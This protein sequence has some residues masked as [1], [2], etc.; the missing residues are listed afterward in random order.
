MKADM[1]ETSPIVLFTYK[2]PWHTRRTVEALQANELALQSDLFVF[3]DAARDEVSVAAVKE[4]REYLRTV[5]GFRSVSLIQREVNRGL[6]ANIID[7]VSRV[8]SRYKRVIVLEDD[9]VTSPFFLRFMNR[10]LNIYEPRPQVFS[11]TG[12]KHPDSLL[13]LP[14]D[15]SADVYL[16]YR[17]ASSGWGTWLDRWQKVDW[18][19]GDFESFKTNRAEQK[20]FN[21]GGADLTDML[22]AYMLGKNDSWAIRWAYARFQNRAYALCPARSYVDNIGHDGTG[23]HCGATDRFHNDL[24]YA[25]RDPVLPPDIEPDPRILQAVLAVHR[26]GIRQYLRRLVNRVR[27]SGTQRMATA[28][29]KDYD[30][31]LGRYGE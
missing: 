7:G 17:G 31:P 4:V 27:I 10:V 19:V 11:I 29:T 24:R 3:S 16:G 6:A 5:D 8:I 2:R 22:F 20:A 18:E 12:Y 26:P 21:R 28:A 25:L 9:L 14:S 1:M 13:R 23:T 15:Y 30:A